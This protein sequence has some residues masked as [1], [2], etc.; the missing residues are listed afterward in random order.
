MS[1]MPELVDLLKWLKAD[2]NVYL[3]RY[4]QSPRLSSAIE[5][6]QTVAES[7]GGKSNN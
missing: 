6:N 7:I 1:V 2:K 4:N 5:H 3:F